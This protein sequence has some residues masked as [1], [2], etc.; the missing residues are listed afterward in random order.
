MSNI[1][2]LA[3]DEV[4]RHIDYLGTKRPEGIASVLFKR[5]AFG[6]KD[7]PLFCPVAT[8]VREES[9]HVISISRR[10]GVKILNHQDHSM[11]ILPESVSE[12]IKQFDAGEFR[13][14]NLSEFQ[15]LLQYTPSLSLRFKRGWSR[16]FKWASNE[17]LKLATRTIVP[18]SDGTV[19][20]P[21]GAP[22]P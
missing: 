13:E 15:Y 20:Y 22:T 21:L 18:Q 19:N 5:C 12:F 16:M 4:K 10:Y 17:N 2:I 14:L 8:Y 9:G 3:R 11:L 1:N 6:I 7:D